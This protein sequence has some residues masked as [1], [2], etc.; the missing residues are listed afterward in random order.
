M[1]ARKAKQLLERMKQR[2]KCS[3][4][5]TSSRQ[6]MLAYPENFQHFPISCQDLPDIFSV[7][8]DSF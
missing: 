1:L 6:I 8:T 5:G 3:T 4:T 2:S 7:S